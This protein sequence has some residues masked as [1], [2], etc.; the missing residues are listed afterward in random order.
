MLVSIEKE[1]QKIVS[2]QKEKVKLDPITEVQN[3][4]NVDLKKDQQ[5]LSKIS[6]HSLYVNN[7]NVLKEQQFFESIE[8]KYGGDVYTIDHIKEMAIKYKLRFVNSVFYAGDFCNQLAPK[9]RTFCKLHKITQNQVE[10]NFYILAPKE[11]LHLLGDIKYNANIDPLMFYKIDDKHYR[12]V[13]KWGNDFTIFRKI[14][15]FK[16]KNF[17]QYWLTNTLTILPL[18]YLLLNVFVENVLTL[19]IY[20]I[21]LSVFVS[22]VIWNRNKIR[23]F[24][25][26]KTSFTPYNWNICANYDKV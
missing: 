22:H 7:Q 17:W 16:W 25:I 13:H 11:M 19:S 2:E 12:L 18:V 23:N 9:I 1:L 14:V 21:G 4:L 24:K 20:S 6:P 26:V 8:K 10:Q 3:I 5:I 15:G